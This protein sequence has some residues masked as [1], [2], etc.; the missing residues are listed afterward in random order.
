MGLKHRHNHGRNI[1]SIDSYAYFSGI[2]R[3]NPDFKVILSLILIIT[4]VIMNN[5]YVSLGIIVITTYI[6]L[7][8]GRIPIGE[9]LRL[10]AIPIAFLILSSIAIIINFSYN[11]VG[12]YY[13]NLNWFYIYCSKENIYTIIN[14]WGKAFGAISAM[15][16]MSLS[17]PS[18][19]LICVLRRMKVPKVIVE[20]MCLTY[21]YIF[22]LMDTQLKMKNSAQ[23][24]LGY[25]SYKRSIY[26]F[27]NIAN[28]L[29]IVSLK[30]ASANFDAM[31]ARCY[32]GSINFLEA[33]KKVSWGQILGSI[34]V[35][36]TLIIV[37]II[38]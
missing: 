18:S 5:L 29:F 12:D 10:M 35:V 4:A 2:N 3:W 6:T 14:L 19:E 28:N 22:I 36:G 11:P 25:S 9:Y 16:M 7:Y 26:T 27:G 31:E 38:T 32:D 8:L 21:R 24:R 23:S 33:E 37:G 30:K 1:A 13:I 17:T 15:Y 34:I 20:L